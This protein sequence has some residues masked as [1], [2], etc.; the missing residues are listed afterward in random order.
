MAFQIG[1]LVIHCRDGLATISSERIIDDQ[2][3]FVIVSKRSDSETIYV[4]KARADIIIRP[5][6]SPTEADQLFDYMNSIP[7]EFNKNTKQRRDLFKR[8]LSS[9]DVKELSYLF[10]QSY[11][12][13]KYPE[14]VRLGPVDYDMLDYSTNNFLDELSITYQV[15]RNEINQFVEKKFK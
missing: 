13:K 3:Y 14:E 15:P 4:P 9:G 12:Y 11:L 8:K 5:I 7:F 2:E 6:M 10:R 1:D